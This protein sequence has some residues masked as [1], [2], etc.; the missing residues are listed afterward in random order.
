MAKNKHKTKRRIFKGHGVSPGIAIGVV[1]RIES[2]TLTI[3]HYWL[4]DNEVTGEIARFQQGLRKTQKELSRIKEKLCHFQ[5]GDQVRIIESHQ[6][7]VNDEMLVKDTIQTIRQEKIN[8]EWAFE[9]VLKKWRSS[10]PATGD[11]YFQERHDELQHVAHRILQNLLG[12]ETQSI[13]TFKKNAVVVAHNLSPTETA[14]MA[15]GTVEGILTSSGGPTS[16]AAIIAR[17]ME[18]PAVA[19]V[20]EIARL[21]REDEMI[22]LDGSAG[23]VILNPS[24]KDLLQYRQLKKKH[25]HFEKLL[26]KEAH[27]PSVTQD[28]FIVRMAANMELMDELPSIK[29]HGAEGIGLF[30]TEMMFL[31]QRRLPTEEEQYH[32][33][34][35]LLQKIAPRPATIRTFDIGGDKIL[36]EDDHLTH[37]DNVNPALGLRAIRYCL[38]NRELLKTQI[39]AM[40]RAARYGNLRILIPMI[41]NL[42]EVRQIKRLIADVEKELVAQKIAVGSPVRV[43]IMVE[44]PSVAI[45]AE[46]FASEVDFFSI[47][48]NDLIQYVLAVDRDNDAVS[49]LYEPLHPAV[50]KLLKGVCDAARARNIEVSLCGEMAGNPLFFLCLLG[51]G[52]TELSMNPVSIPRVKRLTRAVSFRQAADLLNRALDCKTAS[53]VEHLIRREAS[54]I[55]GFPDL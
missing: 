40:L 21:A 12:S 54:K 47:G 50:L 37:D 44:V 34:R 43:G 4:P 1:H 31:S 51:T 2:E 55:E 49:Y 41:T 52:L 48:T 38:R 27:L 26:L 8:A 46:D 6:L 16:H 5:S 29:K 17:A 24:S 25:E 10:L 32:I 36:T 20:D 7:V 3:P 22:L 53:E 33:Y 28:G 39:R 15:K 14:Q 19:G 42:D 45:M 11:N 30:R 18:I 35:D 9:K 23:I 13:R